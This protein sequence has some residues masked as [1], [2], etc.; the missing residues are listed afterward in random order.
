M[1]KRRL[2]RGFDEAWKYAVHSFF[3]EC[4]QLLFPAVHD[5]IDWTRPVE[6]LDAN[7]YRLVPG[8]R[9]RR[10]HTAD[11][12]AKVYFHD[13]IERIVLIHIEIQAQADPMFPLRMYV[14]H[15]H[16][17][18]AYDYPEVVSLAILADND[19]NWRPN[20]FGYQNI[21]SRLQ[22]EFTIVKLLDFDEAALEQ[23]E[24]PF[25]L[26]VLAHLRA[27]KT[28]G[29]PNLLLREKIALIR[30]LK[31][32]GYTQEQVIHLY[33]VVDFM[34]TLS[35]EMEQLVKRVVRQFEE[36]SEWPLTSLEEDAIERGARQGL[37]QGLQ[38]GIIEVTLRVLLRRFGDAAL[39]LEPKLNQV[40]SVEQL[41]ELSMFAL[42]ASTLQ[43]FI[44]A[45]D[46]AIAE[47]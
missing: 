43:E 19:P 8:V 16:I 25:A 33:K 44:Q 23:S 32:R 15:Y 20:A 38:Q 12:I 46:S 10:R 24:N 27:L 9:G 35:Q 4:L 2:R 21:G 28:R 7:L 34:M 40:Q 22:F 30:R 1:R 31:E 6:F 3:R 42:D 45:L 17:F 47:S 41:R 29:K 36:E 39:E 13:G 5:Q 18:D 14:Y 37:E 26:V 11:I